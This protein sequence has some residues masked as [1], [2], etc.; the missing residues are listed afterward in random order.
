VLLAVSLQR[1]HG[2]VIEQYL[3]GLG[4]VGIEMSKLYRTLRQLEKEGLIRSTWEPGPGGPAR[5]TY[6]LTDAGRW[7]L[8]AGATALASQRTLIERFFQL[9]SGPARQA[10]R[11]DEG[12][13]GDRS[14]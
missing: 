12:D 2:Y 1:T 13:E 7:W 11:G 9:Y 6:S 5:R 14:S 4:L 8:E 10:G 3:R